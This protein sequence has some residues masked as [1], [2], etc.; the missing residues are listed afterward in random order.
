MGDHD[1]LVAQGRGEL[2][3]WDRGRWGGKYWVTRDAPRALPKRVPAPILAEELPAAATPAP[4]LWFDLLVMADA[5]NRARPAAHIERS[6]G[7][8]WRET[9]ASLGEELAVPEVPPIVAT[10]DRWREALE[11]G[12]RPT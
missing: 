3:L 4:V 5:A 8:F 7:A 1:D 9:F 6:R 12:R 2:D 10:P 11:K